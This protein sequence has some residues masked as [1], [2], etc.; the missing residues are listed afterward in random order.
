MKILSLY[1]LKGF[2]HTIDLTLVNKYSK[3]FEV[4]KPLQKSIRL[5]TAT[6]HQSHS[7][8]ARFKKEIKIKKI[9]QNKMENAPESFYKKFP[10]MVDH[11]RILPIDEEKL[12]IRT[13][14]KNFKTHPRGPVSFYLLVLVIVL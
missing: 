13:R 4:S 5:E 7:G 12:A 2:K 9:N 8:A 6:N 11:I 3:L 1:K 14:T 10:A